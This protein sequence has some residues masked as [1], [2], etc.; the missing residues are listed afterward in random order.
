VTGTTGIA[1]VGP[2]GLNSTKL[3]SILALLGK[4]KKF[5]L[6]LSRSLH[7]IAPFDELPEEFNFE[8]G[9][10]LDMI[11]FFTIVQSYWQI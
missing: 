1:A 11:F 4:N 9:S 2:G 10:D 5:I 3:F 7:D 8:I 6:I